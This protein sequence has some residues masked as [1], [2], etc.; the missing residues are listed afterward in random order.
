MP[1][2]TYEAVQV[3]KEK[4]SELIRAL[5]KTAAEITAI[6]ETLF[7]VLIKEYPVDN[8]GIGGRPLEEIMKQH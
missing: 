3:T 6:P 5:T 1:N 4:K 7:T 2:I 8:W